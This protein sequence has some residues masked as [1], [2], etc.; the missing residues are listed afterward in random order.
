MMMMMMYFSN[1]KRHGASIWNA[2]EEIWTRLC[3]SKLPLSLK[4]F[5]FLFSSQLEWDGSLCPYNS[6]IGYAMT[7]VENHLSEVF[8]IPLDGTIELFSY[9]LS[10]SPANSR[11][12]LGPPGWLSHEILKHRLYH[13]NSS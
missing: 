11:V 7:A 12:R 4:A 3:S 2:E 9:A 8:S 10:L 1:K 5:P 13:H 6:M